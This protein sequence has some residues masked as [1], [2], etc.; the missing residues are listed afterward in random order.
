MVSDPW[1]ISEEAQEQ[2][3][4]L[5][6]RAAH[7]RGFDTWEAAYHEFRKPGQRE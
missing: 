3:V 4:L 7:D 2:M 6:N 5:A 1:P